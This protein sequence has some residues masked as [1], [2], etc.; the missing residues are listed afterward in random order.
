MKKLL[1]LL[2]FDELSGASMICSPIGASRAIR[3]M[4]SS[5]L[6]TRGNIWECHTRFSAHD[7]CKYGASEKTMNDSKT[8]HRRARPEIAEECENHGP[9]DGQISSTTPLVELDRNSI[10]EGSAAGLIVPRIS[11]CRL[12]T[13]RKPEE[14]GC[15]PVSALSFSC[16]S[17]LLSSPTALGN[18]SGV[19][20][21]SDLGEKM[22]ELAILA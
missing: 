20:C 15:M 2:S 12:V 9:G 7:Q 5:I 4:V 1:K 14:V 13:L 17:K 8:N 19:E 16:N 22:G 11:T 3:E 18:F 6:K 10:R 21:T